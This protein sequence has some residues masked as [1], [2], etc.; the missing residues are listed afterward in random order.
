MKY[1]SLSNNA[2]PGPM[3]QLFV[4]VFAM[5]IVSCRE[6]K[7]DGVNFDELRDS[8]GIFYLEFSVTPYTGKSFEFHENGQKASEIPLKEGK[9]DGLLLQWYADGAK[10]LEVNFKGGKQ[11]DQSFSWFKNGQKKSEKNWKDGKQHGLAYLY[12]EDGKKER[13]EKWKDGKPISYKQ[14]WNSKGGEVDSKEEA[15]K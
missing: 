12:Y 11:C 6:K 10:K 8:E 4:M 14:F 9:I 2:I 5:F 1:S 7:S 13:E 15:E 3:K